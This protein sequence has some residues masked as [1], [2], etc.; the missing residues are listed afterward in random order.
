MTARHLIGARTGTDWINLFDNLDEAAEMHPSSL[1]LGEYMSEFL[2]HPHP[3][4]GRT[5]AVCPFVK[6]SVG[7]HTVWVSF[8]RGTE[9][10]LTHETMQTVIDD[11]FDIFAGLR[12]DYR[13]QVT[14]TVVT[15]FPDLV[16]F[17][18]IDEVHANRKP[19]FVAKGYMLGQ[20][21]PD[22][23]QQGLWNPDFRPLAAPVPM[24]IVRKMM[25]TDYPFLV[26][27]RDWLY[28]YFSQFAPD[29][30]IRLRA[31]MAEK[32]VVADDMIEAFA[33]LRIHNIDEHAK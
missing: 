11:A 15:V 18:K 27:Q 4:L 22:C 9:A 30:P 2:T 29:L 14:Q 21:Y 28:S 10:E 12:R 3:D 6:T 31:S 19:Q 16:D 24:L 25:S 17:T 23:P 8:V 20:F 7:K 33:E 26:G 5:G 13:E 1:V 32:M